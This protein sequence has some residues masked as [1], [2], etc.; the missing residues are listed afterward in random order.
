MFFFFVVLL[1]RFFVCF[2]YVFLIIIF[3]FLLIFPLRLAYLGQMFQCVLPHLGLA[4]PTGDD[5]QLVH[6]S[7]SA[8]GSV[9]A[10]VTPIQCKCYFLWCYVCGCVLV[11][12]LHHVGPAR[13]WFVSS[14][15]E[16]LCKGLSICPPPRL[17]NVK[18]Y[19]V[20]M[21]TSVMRVCA[22]V[23]ERTC[24]C[25]YWVQTRKL[26]CNPS[27]WAWTDILYTDLWH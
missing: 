17:I 18:F 4:P 8:R 23:R 3:V 1:L 27:E 10:P 13:R 19:Y 12:V 26:K 11:C 21:R 5:S 6:A 20:L 2:L 15:L 16:H 24:A 22:C 7:A 9:S 14:T 25:L